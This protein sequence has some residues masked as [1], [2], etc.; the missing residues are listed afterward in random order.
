MRVFKSPRAAAFVVACALFGAALAVLAARGGSSSAA[1]PAQDFSGLDRRLGMLE[2]R[3]YR[4]ETSINQLERQAAMPAR[5]P[6]ASSASSD[7]EL[8]LLRAEF[9]ALRR[10]LGEVECGLVRLD[11]RTTA[12]EACAARGRTPGAATD[13]C[14]RD[15]QAPLTLST[16]P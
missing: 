15:A 12:E 10:R 16:R 9:E 3:L 13:P 6:G 11:E 4:I 7:A 5:V 14:R 2:Q 8:G 1:G